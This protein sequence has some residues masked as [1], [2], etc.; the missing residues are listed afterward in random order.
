MFITPH[1]TEGLGISYEMQIW[2]A[3]KDNFLDDDNC[4]AIHHFPLFYSGGA[5][6]R[7][8]DILFIHRHFGIF[9]IEVK[10]LNISNIQ[11]IQGHVWHYKNFRESQGKPYEQ[12]FN[13]MIMLKEDLEEKT[14]LLNRLRTIN[15]VALPNI[16]KEEWENKG[17]SNNIS[18][19]TPIL[20]DDLSSLKYKIEYYANSSLKK[21]QKINN[22][23]WQRILKYFSI[24]INFPKKYI[25]KDVYESNV[26]SKTF[27]LSDNEIEDN[28]KEIEKSLK[29]GIK[30]YLF[31]N[32]EISKKKLEFLFLNFIKA[33]QLLIHV[34]K[35]NYSCVEINS[36]IFYNGENF[37]V[38]IG[39][40]YKDFNLDQYAAIHSAT[41]KSIIIKAGAGTGKTHV[42]IDRILY[43]VMHKKVKLNEIIMITFTNKST[44]EM[45]K[46]LEDKFLELFNLT[47]NIR[48][49]NYAEDVMSM[50]I[51][52]IHSFA[53]KVI[54]T[55]SHEV[56]LGSNVTIRNFEY[57]KTKIIE[58]LI[59]DYF[60]GQ[61]QKFFKQHGLKHHQLIKIIRELWLEIEKKGLSEKDIDYLDWG[62]VDE[63][64]KNIQKLFQ[65]IFSKCE[66][67]LERIKSEENAITMGDLIRYLKKFTKNEN[68]LNQLNPNCFLFVDEFQDSDSIQIE[69]ISK[70]QEI[71]NY[72][73]FVVGDIKQSIYRFRGADYLSF[74]ELKDKSG[75]ENFIE[76]SL[77]QNYRSSSNLLKMMDKVFTKWGQ[78]GLLP[79]T[80]ND[81]LNSTITQNYEDSIWNIEKIDSKN[82]DNNAASIIKKALKTI[83]ST[84][85]QQAKIALIVR[86]NKQAKKIKKIC[87]ELNIQTSENIDGNFYLTKPI[88]D[89]IK[90]LQGLMFSNEAQYVVNAI[91]SSYF[92]D[93]IHFNELLRFQGKSSEICD[94]VHQKSNQKLIKYREGIRENSLM[95]VIQ[96][97]IYEENLYL[98]VYKEYRKHFE[99]EYAKIETK[100]Y[101]RNLQHLM[102]I[103]ENTFTQQNI[104]I[105]TLYQWLLLQVKT[106]R[107]ENEPV[108][109]SETQIIISTVHRAKGLEFDTVIL[110]YTNFNYTSK[111]TGYYIGDSVN[112]KGHYCI[113][114]EIEGSIYKYKDEPDIVRY[115]NNHIKELE[116]IEMEEQEKEEVRLLYVALT[117]A[118]QRIFIQKISKLQNDN[119]SYLLNRAN[120]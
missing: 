82:V 18:S 46:R 10:G 87:E 76:L 62:E 95:T 11:S 57:E 64:S 117:R 89:L 114:W 97:I 94:Y 86:T 113:G 103:I 56:G 19:G 93:E 37:N 70:L 112:D 14:M 118:K 7:E 24:D 53:K 101:E 28:I 42:M 84:P 33:H 91:N 36:G 75:E 116:K 41:E 107:T 119:W 34:R 106:N 12:G 79:Y 15:L 80:S 110:P 21:K 68:V 50:Q 61:P 78:Q 3:L 43:L 108:F 111:K 32:E 4:I 102:M 26:F 6:R 73:L 1:Y 100:R 44:I 40:N 71:L 66:S 49:L 88:D 39:L 2:E 85:N 55:L 67:N 54:Q 16:S 51:S 9:V 60:I 38:E 98:Q 115:R 31:I 27:I 5:T 59:D 22:Q 47:K 65:F 104:S 20:K 30:I 120:C 25:D 96:K 83:K 35:E 29:K 90:L 52:T 58:N 48:F 8:I 63:E 109:I 23:E 81:K 99:K 105:Y 74:T 45:K 13:Q 69:L 77:Q 92:S 72:K 17:F